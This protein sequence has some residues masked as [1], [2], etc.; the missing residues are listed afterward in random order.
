[1]RR[2]LTVGLAGLALSA[3]GLLTAPAASAHAF[4]VTSNPGD[5]AVVRTAP[6]VLRL[7]FSE[8]VVLGATR[9]ELTDSSGRVVQPTS[10]RIEQGQDTEE[11][12][13]VLATLPALRRSAYR[14]SWQTLSSD[15]LHRTSGLFVFGVGTAVHAA[16]FVEPLPPAGGSGAALGGVHR[17]GVRARRPAARRLR[18][19]GRRER[20]A[21]QARPTTRRCGCRRGRGGDRVA[22]RRPARSQRAACERSALR[23]VRRAVGAARDRPGDLARR[24]RPPL[25]DRPRRAGRPRG[26]GRGG[27]GVRRSRLGPARPRRGGPVARADAR[28]GRCPAPDRRGRPGSGWCSPRPCCCP[29]PRARRRAR[30]CDASGT[31]PPRAWPR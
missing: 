17:N 9:I 3:L 15:D 31:R 13:H 12:S 1:M 23:P 25:Q 5:G 22:A 20:R 30:C 14:V 19:T 28:A 4:L 10:L 26:R 29:G 7:D 16:P 18:A 21:D 2:L 6:S 11:P 24:G 27:G 8:S